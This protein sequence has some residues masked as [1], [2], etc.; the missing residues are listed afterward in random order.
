MSLWRENQYESSVQG[1]V[2]KAASADVHHAGIVPI[3]NKK[4]AA[5]GKES[6]VR[7][8]VI[9]ENYR[10]FDLLKN[11]L[12]AARHSLLAAK[13]FIGKILQHSAWPID[14]FENGPGFFAEVPFAF[15]PRTVR[16]D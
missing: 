1:C 4:M 2:Q 15:I 12:E 14:L 3:A 13:I 7:K 10:L 16:D 6:R 5:K 11:P 8:A 9:L